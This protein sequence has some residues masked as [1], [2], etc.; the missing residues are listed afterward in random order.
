MVALPSSKLRLADSSCPATAAFGF[1]RRQGVLG[2]EHVEI[3]FGHAQQQ[4]LEGLLQP[5]FGVG[6]QQLDCS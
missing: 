6:G 3:G 4:I 2:V 1:G 5:H